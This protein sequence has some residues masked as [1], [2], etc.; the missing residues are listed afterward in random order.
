MVPWMIKRTVSVRQRHR[1]LTQETQTWT[2][3][4]MVETQSSRMSSVENI[5]W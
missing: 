2:N 5:A 4:T 1:Q 3:L